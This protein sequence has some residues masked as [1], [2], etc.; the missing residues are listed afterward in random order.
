MVDIRGFVSSLLKTIGTETKS[1]YL[2]H[3]IHL[4]MYKTGHKH[5][6]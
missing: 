5:I 6:L 1:Q 2:S 4:Y 3:T